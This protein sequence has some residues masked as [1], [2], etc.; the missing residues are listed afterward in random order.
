MDLVAN[1]TA[2]DSPLTKKHRNWYVLDDN[3]KI[4]SP[5]TLED[6]HWI[7]WKDLA[8]FDFDKT[9]DKQGL[10]NYLLEVCRYYISLG[11]TGFRCDAAYHVSSDFWA[12]LISSLKSEFPNILFLAETFV[13]SLSQI[14]SLVNSG[15]DYIFNSSKWW[16]FSDAWCLQQYEFT[17]KICPSIS[18]PETHDTPR[19]M[20]ELKG[21]MASFLQR[22]YFS[23]FFS[24]GFMIVSGCEYGFRKQ[25]NCVTTT[26]D[27]WENTGQDFSSLIK[28]LLSVKKLL[29]PLHEESAVEVISQANQEVLCLLKT[30]ERDRV[31]VVLNKDSRHR[32]HLYLEDIEKLLQAKNIRN[33]L[34][35]ERLPSH[36]ESMNRWL[37]PG[38]VKVFAGEK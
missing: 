20:E 5:Q 6:G 30:W 7:T 12:Y 28:Q 38:E 1:H 16:N 13:C 29:K 21:D 23:C 18:F 10:W 9:E 26:P 33:F 17:R 19:L 34:A 32:Q 35:E 36:I 3:G 22:L 11:F 31:L 8:K 25:I 2:I 14:Q 24:K 27:D 37:R 15:F 4:L